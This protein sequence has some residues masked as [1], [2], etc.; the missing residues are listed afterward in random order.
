MTHSKMR[1]GPGGIFDAMKGGKHEDY[2]ANRSRKEHQ[3]QKGKCWL[4]KLLASN[5]NTNKQKNPTPQLLIFP[6]KIWRIHDVSLLPQQ[7]IVGL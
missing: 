2:D 4:I 7:I 6:L 3:Q 1:T 5:N